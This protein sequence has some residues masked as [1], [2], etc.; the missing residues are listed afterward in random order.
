M[1]IDEE[2]QLHFKDGW[3]IIPEVD[4]DHEI[5]QLSEAI[6]W[7]KLLEAF[8]SFYSQNHGR[9][10]KP[11]RAKIGLLILK[12]LYQL[13]DEEVVDQ[14]GYNLYFQYFC[15]VHIT[16][17][18]RFID[19]STLTLF[20]KQ[21]GVEGIKIL[22]QQLFQ[23]LKEHKQLKG[24]KLICDTTVVPSPIQYPTDVHLAEKVRRKL[25]GLIDQSKK[26]GAPWVRTYKRVAKRVFI[27]YQKIRKHTQT[28]RKKFQ[29]KLVRFADRNL[30]QL[31]ELMEKIPVSKKSLKWK[32]Q[33]GELSGLSEKILSQQK[34]L[35]KRHPVKERIVSLW[36]P[37]I[38]PMVRGKYPV[39][40]EFGPK[41]LCNLKNK[42]LFLQ[43]SS[44]ENRSDH[45]W[46]MT[47][48]EN[49]HNQF[50]HVP[51]EMAT[52]R[53]FYSQANVLRAKE[54]GVG[55]VGIHPKGK[56]PPGEFSRRTWKRLISLRSAIEAK[57]SLA[58]RRF[59]L[60]RIQYRARNGEE[61]WIRMGLL[62]MNWRQ[63][64]NS[65]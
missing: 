8:S 3:F 40:V 57:I 25:V 44:F 45:D 16:H 29:G 32:K 39:E 62:A 53:G 46:M 21:I 15:D 35:L 23:Y 12:H 11:T 52:D 37:H 36:A 1:Y 42:F 41:I 58:K 31:K 24:K 14:M 51:T 6:D 59:G 20:R 33:A 54:F 50:G 18:K 63:T 4:P 38:R 2:K 55:K 27:T 30:R 17:A 9:P 64:L 22:E 19:P 65:G 56:K 43:D 60:D 48:L 34:E 47:S 13:S 49:Y 5:I 28:S 7:D 10:T 26:L 61:L